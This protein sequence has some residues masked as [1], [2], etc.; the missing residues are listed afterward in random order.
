MGEGGL[1]SLRGSPPGEGDGFGYATF[2][3]PYSSEGGYIIVAARP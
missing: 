1:L 2:G 3:T